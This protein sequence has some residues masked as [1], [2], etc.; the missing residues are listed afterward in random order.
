MREEAITWT[1]IHLAYTEHAQVDYYSLEESPWSRTTIF[2]VFYVIY[3]TQT[4]LGWMG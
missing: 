4:V 2:H 3:S 1:V